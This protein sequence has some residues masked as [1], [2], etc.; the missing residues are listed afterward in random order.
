[1]TRHSVI[2]GCERSYIL[3]AAKL[4]RKLSAKLVAARLDLPFWKV[5]HIVHRP[6]RVLS[7]VTAFHRSYAN[8][9][10]RVRKRLTA[11]AIARRLHVSVHVVRYQARGKYRRVERLQVARN[12]KHR[13]LQALRHVPRRSTATGDSHGV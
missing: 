10:A 12:T 6:N 1:M 13:N 9:A 5:F 3:R 11:R 2:S 8:R 4:S 7:G